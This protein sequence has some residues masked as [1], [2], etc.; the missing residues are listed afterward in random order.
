MMT[1]LCK[2][3]S[4]APTTGVSIAQGSMIVVSKVCVLAME[5]SMP[6]R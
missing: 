3:V 2:S 6:V 1:K 5:S 4:L